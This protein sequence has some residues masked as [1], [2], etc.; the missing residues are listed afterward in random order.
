MESRDG[1]D[2]SVARKARAYIDS[3][4][5]EIL[6]DRAR[7]EGR[8]RYRRQVGNGMGNFFV[9]HQPTQQRYHQPQQNGGGF[10]TFLSG[11]FRAAKPMFMPILK[12]LGKQALATSVAVVG[13]VAH[14]HDWRESA[15]RRFGETGDEIVT[16]VQN[17]VQKLMTGSG[18]HHHFHHPP[19]KRAYSSDYEYAADMLEGRDVAGNEGVEFSSHP[20]NSKKRKREAIQK[21]LSIKPP[22][23]VEGSSSSIS[24]KRSRSV[25]VKPSAKGE[26]C[27]PSQSKKSKKSKNKKKKKSASKKKSKPKKKSTASKKKK[28]KQSAKPKSKKKNK[29]ASSKKQK[30]SKSAKKKTKSKKKKSPEIQLGGGFNSWL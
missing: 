23:G 9:A 3:F 30:K 27:L 19:Q 20:P 11:L 22:P 21:L 5:D 29:S 4:V 2:P 8:P 6:D 1:L 13:D 17:K 10:G 12:N 18:V 7:I 28:K 25:S 15:K 26:G 14:G 16:Q 24:R